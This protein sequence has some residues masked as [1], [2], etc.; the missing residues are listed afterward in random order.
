VTPHDERDDY[1]EG[2]PRQPWLS[3]ADWSIIVGIGTVVAFWLKW[4]RP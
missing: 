1:A 4:S 2:P 3:W